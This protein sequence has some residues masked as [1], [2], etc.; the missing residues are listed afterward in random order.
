MIKIYGKNC[1]YEAI[2]AKS[3]IKKIYLSFEVSKKDSKFLCMLNDKKISYDIVDKKQMDQIFGNGHQG[4]GA[5]REEYKIYNEG[6][7][8]EIVGTSKR[9]LLL[10]GI[11]DPH[12]LGAIIRSVDAFG[13]DAVILPKNRSCSITEAVAHVSTGAI[14]HV[15]IAYVNSLSTFALKL[16]E[17]GYWLCGTDASGNDSLESLDLSLDLAVI[18]GSEGFGMNKTL[19]KMVD[20]LISIPMIGHVN[21]LNASVST[22]IVLYRTRKNG[23]IL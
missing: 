21:S 3:R 19:L 8:D 13:Y 14:E 22:G 17:K 10:D 16:K 6:I 5:Y 23:R 2:R 20:Y 4:Y 7:I 1:I 18:I 15:K 9:L 11:M 12:N